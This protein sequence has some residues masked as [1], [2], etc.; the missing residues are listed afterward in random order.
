M[1]DLIDGIYHRRAIR[2]Y[3]DVPVNEELLRFVIA[4]AVQAPNGMNRQPWS[5]LVVRNRV[6]LE[7]C[8]ERAKAHSLTALSHSPHLAA[9]R[10]YLDSPTFNIFYNAP[11]LIIICA[12]EPDPMAQQDCCLAAENLMLAAHE[13]ALGTCWIGFAASW[14]NQPE[15]KA[16]FK[17]PP[18]HAPVAPIIIGYPRGPHPAP[19]RREPD[20]RWIEG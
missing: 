3:A 9:F 10:Q 17:I 1:M 8:S 19:P 14:L 18:E 7:R 13:R 6:V 15:G 11:A 2:D 16:E 12:T 5:F 20:I 4:A